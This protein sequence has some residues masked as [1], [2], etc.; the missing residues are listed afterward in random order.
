MHPWRTMQ[1]H[2]HASHRGIRVF[3]H[4][5]ERGEIGNS[6]LTDIIDKLFPGGGCN[7]DAGE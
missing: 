4:C 6:Q 1:R 3:H 2:K 7:D 5:G